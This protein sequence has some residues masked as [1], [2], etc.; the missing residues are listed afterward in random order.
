MA[1]LI[2]VSIET[3]WASDLVSPTL[4]VWANSCERHDVGQKATE[5]TTYRLLSLL[6]ELDDVL[7]VIV[8]V[9]F[10]EFL[11]EAE[12]ISVKLITELGHDV[13]IKC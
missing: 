4:M 11:V 13:S 2:F 12:E 5:H 10:H 8:P 9:L 6:L 1:T 3:F 7:L